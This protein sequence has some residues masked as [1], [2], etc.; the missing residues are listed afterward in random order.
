MASHRCFRC[1][2][3]WPVSRKNVTCLR[4]GEKL[5]YA[6]YGIPLNLKEAEA[7]KR[8]IE[9]EQFYEKWDAERKGPTPEEIGAQQAREIHALER[10]PELTEVEDGGEA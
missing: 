4:C 5:E 1:G 3:E 6:P 8:E 10:I 9:F 2:I 7:L